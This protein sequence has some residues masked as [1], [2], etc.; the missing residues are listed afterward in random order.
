MQQEDEIAD[1]H[2]DAGHDLGVTRHCA[3]ASPGPEP[4]T[5]ARMIEKPCLQLRRGPRKARQRQQH[6]V[7]SWKQGHHD[8]DET[9]TD[10]HQ[11]SEEHTSELQSL[12]RHSY[13]V[14]CLKKKKQHTT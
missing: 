10:E 6:E 11:R 1:A 3:F 2:P 4:R 5:E 7:C 14:F 9:D 13:A 8:A 12:M